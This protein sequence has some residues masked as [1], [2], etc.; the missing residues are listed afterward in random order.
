MGKFCPELDRELYR[1]RLSKEKLTDLDKRA[2]RLQSRAVRNRVFEASESK[3]EADAWRDVFSLISDD[4]TFEMLYSFFGSLTI[5]L[6]SRK[7]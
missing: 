4:D 7:V 1:A 3:W 2:H 5:H 6:W